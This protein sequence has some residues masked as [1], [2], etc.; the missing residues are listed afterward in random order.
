MSKT[1]KIVIVA[2]VLIAAA[3]LA[4]H[5]LMQPKA[6][7]DGFGGVVTAVND[8]SVVVKGQYTLPNNPELINSSTE[9]ELTIKVDQSTKITRELIYLPTSSEL[10]ASGGKFDPRTARREKTVGTLQNM[11][12]DKEQQTVSIDVKADGNI[13][14]KSQFTAKEITYTIAYDPEFFGEAQ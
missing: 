13:Y 6:S 9:R 12:Q 11:R 4:A 3:A 2:V 8:H 10:Q 7:T 5:K 1:L 14:G